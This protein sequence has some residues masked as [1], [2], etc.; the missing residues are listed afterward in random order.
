MSVKPDQILYSKKDLEGMLCAALAGRAAEEISFG[1]ENVT[2]G[3]SDDIKKAREIASAM[4]K[5]FMMGSEWEDEKDEKGILEKAME[6]TRTLLKK[7]Q[8]A[9]NALSKELLEK[10][11]LEKAGW[12]YEGIGWYS[13]D[14]KAVPLYRLYNPN[15][16]AGAHH[17]TTSESETKALIDAGWIGEGI[18]WYGR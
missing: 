10:E 4:A 16:K 1:K 5:D 2:T 12:A 11:T 6:K 17:Y 7:Y 15:A 9:L 8:D 3:A 18:A 14:A 13:D